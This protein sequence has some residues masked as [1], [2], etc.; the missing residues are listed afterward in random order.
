M[1]KKSRIAGFSVIFAQMTFIS[2]IR[3]ESVETIESDDGNSVNESVSRR[4]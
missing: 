1:E 2:L 4:I 3:P